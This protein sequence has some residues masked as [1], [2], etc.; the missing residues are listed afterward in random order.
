M[1]QPPS[2]AVQAWVQG[3]AV[4]LV[5]DG[6]GTEVD[7]ADVMITGSVFAYDVNIPLPA[8]DQQQRLEK[9]KGDISPEEFNRALQ[10]AQHTARKQ[11]TLGQAIM[12]VG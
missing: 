10:W 9:I 4:L 3:K 8:D 1:P 2:L 6:S 11:I 7:Q 5:E 12:H